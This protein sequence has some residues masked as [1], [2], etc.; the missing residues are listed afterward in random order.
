[1]P[2]FPGQVGRPDGDVEKS[3]L[4]QELRGPREPGPPLMK[5]ALGLNR[6]TRF[7]E[8]LPIGPLFTL[9]N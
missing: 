7:D 8:F 9:G 2:A 1:M 6:V 3:G 5:A 4:G